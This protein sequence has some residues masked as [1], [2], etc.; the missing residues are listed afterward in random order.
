MTAL[1]ALADQ[2]DAWAGAGAVSLTENAGVLTVRRLGGS[3]A[4]ELLGLVEAAGLE[5]AEVYDEGGPVPLSSLSLATGVTVSVGMPASPTGVERILTCTAFEAAL[6]R[7]AAAARIWVLPLGTPFETRGAR[8]GPWEDTER[9]EPAT[10]CADPRKV[11]RP[12][13]PYGDGEADL[14]RWL[15][16]DPNGW[17]SEN[18]PGGL[19]WRRQAGLALAKALANEIEPDGRLLFRGPPVSRFTLD[20]AVD[21]DDDGFIALQRAAD[22]AYRNRPEV[23]N[24]HGLLTAEIARAGLRDSDL[25]GLSEVASSA[26]EGAR[27]AYGFGV[28]QQSRDTLKALSDL[29]RAVLDET[30][31]VSEITR[32]LAGAV[33]GAVFGGIG[34]IV[35]RLTL[36]AN[37]VF[38]GPA[39]LLLGVVLVLYV[40]ATVLSGTH[41][42]MQQR[43]LRELWK[44]K[45]YNFLTE[46]EYKALV[47][48]PVKDAEIAFW[49]ASG[50][51]GLMTVLL[52]AAVVSIS[53]APKPVAAPP[54]QT[55]LRAPAPAPETPKKDAPPVFEPKAASKLEPAKAQPRG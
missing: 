52:F 48:K 44:P 45:L 4:A 32:A 17:S 37:A 30:A 42:L 15:L 12:L 38:V 6:K 1:R 21:L 19:V 47:S 49:I 55:T 34:V 26:L 23:E 20:S 27:I 40:G 16:V 41:F 2:L 24:R 50:L 3:Q 43:G 9:V 22:W 13:G 18:D 54:V 5:D 36:P 33:A 25:T 31:K 46:T 14:C 35:A 28:Q 53:Q 11:V 10:V 7:P 51:G 39:A 8:Y 29:R